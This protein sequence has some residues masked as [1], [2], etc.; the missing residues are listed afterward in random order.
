MT[1]A[2]ILEELRKLP[3]SERLGIIEAA[4]HLTRQEMQQIEQSPHWAEEQR[5]LALAAQTLL[6]DYAAGGEL[7]EFTVLDSEDFYA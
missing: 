1:P 3:P 2:E 4:L 7:T 6:P 5:Q